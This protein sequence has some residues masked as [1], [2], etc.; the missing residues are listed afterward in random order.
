MDGK[1]DMPV[2]RRYAKQPVL[3]R[4]IDLLIREGRGFK[5]APVAARVFRGHDA[6]V[7]A[8]QFSRMINVGGKPRAYHL[9]EVNASRLVD[10]LNC[11]LES[12]PS[13]IIRQSSSPFPVTLDD[14]SQVL[15]PEDF[16]LSRLAELAQLPPLMSVP[17]DEFQIRLR[18]LRGMTPFFKL[19]ANRLKGS[20]ANANQLRILGTASIDFARA[21]HFSEG[22]VGLAEFAIEQGHR[23]GGHLHRHALDPCGAIVLGATLHHNFFCRDESDMGYGPLSVSTAEAMLADLNASRGY[24][25]S[26]AQRLEGH[27]AETAAAGVH[28]QRLQIAK[29]Y[30]RMGRIADA[31]HILQEY[32]NANGPDT[33]WSCFV[34]A[35]ISLADGNKRAAIQH[36][37]FGLSEHVKYDHSRYLLDAIRTELW[38]LTRDSHLRDEAVRVA[39]DKNLQVRCRHMLDWK[40]LA[41][42]IRGKEAKVGGS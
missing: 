7:A 27:Q 28:S 32:Q 1:V 34:S 25:E 6:N 35:K 15:R 42:A 36:L 21:G 20:N 23:V 39:N 18:A 12:V 31:L 16:A 22:E 4:I 17:A 13:D 11:A 33:P 14:I 5:Q 40:A 3:K 26:A 8:A 29:T 41:E 19:A 30:A 37:Q 38:L 2:L 10:E 24:Y 9:S